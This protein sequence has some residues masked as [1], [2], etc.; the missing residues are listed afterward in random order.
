MNGAKVSVFAK[1][2]SAI[3]A[4][5]AAIYVAARLWHLT[6][7]SLWG[8]ESFG[9]YGAR[10]D[11]SGLFSYVVADVAH[12][13]LFYMLLKVWIAMGGE[14]LLWLKLLP[15]LIATATLL[16]FLLLCRE[17]NLQPAERNL[18]FTLAA[19]NGYLI[20]FAQGVRMYSLL[21]F[22]GVCSFW[23]FVR[24]FNSEINTKRDLWALCAIN[25]LLVYTHYFGWLV[26]GSEFA[27]LLFWGRRKRF[28]FSLSVVAL[29]VCFSPWAYLVTGAALRQAGLSIIDWIPRPN[30]SDVAHF[31]GTLNGP[32]EFPRGTSVGLLL[33]GSPILLWGWRIMRGS[34]EEDKRSGL[35]FWLLFL[36]SFLPTAFVY[37][38]S[39][40]LPQSVWVERY[41]IFMAIPYLI[42][43]AIAVNRLRPNWLRTTT[44]LL[45]VVWSALAGLRDLRSNRIAW[46]GQGAQL[47]SRV[48]WEDLTHQ[49]IQ[50]EPSQAGDI[51]I[52]AVSAIMNG[53]EIGYWTIAESMRY[54]LDSFNE[55]RF[56]FVYAQDVSA[57]LSSVQE[58]HFWVA[59]FE[60]RHLKK[61]PPQRVLE[62]NGY[63]VGEELQFGQIDNRLVLFPVWRQ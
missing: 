60:S 32:L 29:I 13:P 2:A 8:G 24:F 25:L 41:L 18:A 19:V 57:L 3:L 56:Q 21:M 33:F 12:P 40:F 30:L 9:I 34:Q 63:R 38:V 48:T 11:W 53:R 45:L 61:H 52:Y 1:P 14:S 31:Y 54:Y 20:H 39:Q 15:V 58:N 16:P 5:V 36:F 27:F 43:V 49:L 42:L 59:F 7:Y 55:K 37:T 6:A 50:A 4:L 47:G 28:S 46:A 26:V 10:Q 51:K 17:L 22:F 62:E 35:T 23:L 44:V